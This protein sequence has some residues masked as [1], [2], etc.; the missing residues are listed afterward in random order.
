MMLFVTVVIIVIIVI[1]AGRGS[2]PSRAQVPFIHAVPGSSLG[3]RLN[4]QTNGLW[5]WVGGLRGGDGVV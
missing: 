3:D 2:S 1:V 5:G 4:G